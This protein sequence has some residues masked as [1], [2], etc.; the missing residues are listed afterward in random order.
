MG[1]TEVKAPQTPSELKLELARLRQERLSKRA[2]RI[3]TPLP[4]TSTP[5]PIAIPTATTTT[6]TTTAT[7]K[8][9]DSKV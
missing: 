1:W 6:T 8:E 7:E 5:P 9:E 3:G 4:P 2:D